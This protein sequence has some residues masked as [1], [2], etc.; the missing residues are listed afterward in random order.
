MEGYLVSS[1]II[2]HLTK[3]S[4]IVDVSTRSALRPVFVNYIYRVD[5]NAQDIYIYYEHI[6]SICFL[7]LQ[8]LHSCSCVSVHWLSL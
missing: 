1:V 7:S 8:C 3:A 5:I 4:V 6:A 2:Y